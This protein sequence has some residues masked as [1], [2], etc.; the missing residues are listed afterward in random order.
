MTAPHLLSALDAAA[1]IRAGA[2]TSEALVESCLARIEVRDAAVSAWIHL[3]AD[4]ALAEA[5]QRDREEPRS[6]LHGVPAGIKD[7]IDTH[8]MPTGYGSPIYTPD[9]RPAW[10]AA[11]VALLREAGMVVLGKTVTT[12]FAMRHPGKTMNPANPTHTPGGSSQGSAAGVADNQVPVAIGTQTAGSVVRPASYCGAVGFKPTFG[13]VPRAGVKP[14]SET[15]DTVGS[16]ARTVADASAFV[17]AMAGIPVGTVEA[18]KARF[19]VCPS[20][21]WG[22]VEPSSAHAM[23]AAREAAQ[24]GAGALTLPPPCDE[25]LAA[26]DVIMPYEAARLLAW[27]Y[28]TRRKEMSE[29]IRHVV[30]T[31]LGINHARYLWALGIREAARAAFERVFGDVDALITPAAPGEAPEGLGWT[32]SPECNR[33]WTTLGVPCITLPGLTGETGLPVGVQLVGRSG[34]DADLLAA[35]AWLHPHLAG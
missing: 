1:A 6:A 7:I 17:Q 18:R 19:S 30:E 22:E 24:A 14:I 11:P 10:D 13:T 12:E 29:A 9:N 4:A 23:E 28:R 31:G 25:V 33:I 5:R 35:A 34:G 26:H 16:M 3:D 20:P 2:L 32:G 15:L 8:D 27:E 21:A